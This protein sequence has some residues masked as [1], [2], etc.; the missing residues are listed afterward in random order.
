MTA[1]AGVE[2][3]ALTEE[4]VVARVM[5]G[6][7]IGRGGWIVTPNVDICRQVSRDAEARALV[8]RAS[9]VVAD[10]MPLVWASRLGGE[11]LPE[12]V[13]GASLIFSL[14]AAAAA[15]GRSVYLLGGEPGVPDKAAAELPVPLSRAAGGGDRRAATR[16]RPG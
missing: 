11:P 2:F 9:V 4:Q 14:S 10:G 6:L 12:R 8:G 16:L 7:R 13:T 3:D 15:G 5:E 1:V